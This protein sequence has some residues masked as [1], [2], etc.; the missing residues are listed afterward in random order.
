[1]PR[2]TSIDIHFSELDDLI[3][4]WRHA[5]V[6]VAAK[7]VPPHITL[8]YP[9]TPGPLRDADVD[10]LGSVIDQQDAFSLQLTGIG[11]F[12]RTRALYLAVDESAPLRR[13]M[14]GIFSAFPDTPPYRGAFPDPLPHVTI[15][16]AADDEELDTLAE[17]IAAHVSPHLPIEMAVQEVVIMEEGDD[18]LWRI[19]ATLPLGRFGGGTD[20]R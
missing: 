10:R 14:Q 7:G 6:S 19:C 16:T 5:T 2:E 13:M 18:S 1:M 12:Q 8:L 3:G 9:W 15:A 20:G 4:R 11:M 17:E